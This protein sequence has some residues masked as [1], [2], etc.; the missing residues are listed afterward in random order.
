MAASWT[1]GV[2]RSFR[3]GAR[4][5]RRVTLSGSMRGSASTVP[6][7]SMCIRSTSDSISTISSV[8]RPLCQSD[9]GLYSTNNGELVLFAASGTNDPSAASFNHDF[10]NGTMADLLLTRD[11]TGLFSAFINGHLAF[12]GLETDGAT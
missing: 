12:R 10:T 3:K 8:H 11:A 1:A 4:S 6:A 2:H 5:V 9:S 7:H